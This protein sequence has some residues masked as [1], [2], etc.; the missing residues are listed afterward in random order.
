M[1]REHAY[2][3]Y[4]KAILHF[5]KYGQGSKILLCFHGYGQSNTD[6]NV[7][8]E[9]LKE[10]YT[11][12]TFD[13]FYHGESFWHQKEKP[14]TKL[15]WFE[16]IN[17]F[18]ATYKIQRFSLAGFSM[19]AKFVLPIVESFSERIDKLLLIAPDGITINVW[20]R[21]ATSFNW[22]RALLR[23]LVVKPDWYLR[24][25][26]MLIFF[27]LAPTSVINL[28]NSKMVTRR[29]RRRVYYSWVVF[30]VLRINSKDIANLINKYNIQ[31]MVFLGSRDKLITEISVR[32]LLRHTTNYQKII[33]KAGHTNLLQSVADYERNNNI[34]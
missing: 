13:L 22:T 6:M 2:F 31:L 19:G 23:S 34:V 26:K 28:A 11:I 33:L 10:K 17:A 20:Y 16:L 32:P 25:I 3:E 14:L 30:R 18:L 9:A 4:K 27:K 21:I 29:Q 8:Q 15:F 1:N 7:L 12:Y 24:M 5:S